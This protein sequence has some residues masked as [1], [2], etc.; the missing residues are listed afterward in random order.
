MQAFLLTGMD[1]ICGRFLWQKRGTAQKPVSGCAMDNG[2]RS[3]FQSPLV[4]S[5]KV[6]VGGALGN[7]IWCKVSVG[8]GSDG[9]LGPF[10]PK[11]FCG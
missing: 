9:L 2:T 3:G 8:L 7:L 11:Q 6:M 5:K 10:Q 4:W 1:G